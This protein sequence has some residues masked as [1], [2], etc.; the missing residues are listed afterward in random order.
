MKRIL[1]IALALLMCATMLT[2]CGPSSND[3]Q[4]E[5]NP[6]ETSGKDEKPGESTPAPSGEGVKITDAYTFTD[7]TDLDF[8][9]RY[10][11]YMGPE[12][13]VVA[14]AADSGLTAQYIILYAKEE[15]A[16]AS[17]NLSIFDTAESAK[18]NAEAMAAMGTTM[19]PVE[20][21]D[22]VMYSYTDAD[23]MELVIGSLNGAGVIPDTKASSFAKF[24][25]E[26][27][28]AVLVE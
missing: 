20:G 18:A 21:D 3:D 14:M 2:A 7:P 9:A 6:P 4:T 23:A 27:N 16:L 11:L 22:T 25:V 26:M 15:K 19:N 28:A 10:V 8:D 24:Q 17:Y 12:N 13:P 1:C 5:P